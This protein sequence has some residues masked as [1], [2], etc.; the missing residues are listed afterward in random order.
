MT[1]PVLWNYDL[2]DACYT[3]RL[4]ASLAGVE[5]ELRAVDAYPG[6]EHLGPEYLARNPSGRLPMLEH[7][8]LR[9]CHLAAILTHF[10]RTGPRGATYLPADPA[11]VARM[12]DWLAFAT[13]DYVV[14]ADARAASVFG[15]TGDVDSLRQ[16]SVM[17][18]RLLEDHM[19]AQTL[20]GQHFVAGDTPSV[21]DVALFPGFALSR[22]SNI[23]HDAFPALRNWARRIRSLEGFV[24]MP[25][26]PEYH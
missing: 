19:V 3:A 15:S 25:G 23:D 7:G 9:L 18:L 22:D 14:L 16:A 4:M 24:T 20:V 2:D 17:T 11:E 26:I 8:D 6:G 10:A 13:G 5:P 12:E 1:S 21:A